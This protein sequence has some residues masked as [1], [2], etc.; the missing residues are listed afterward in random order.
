MT[1]PLSWGRGRH[2]R[3]LPPSPPPLF[4]ERALASPR[5]NKDLTEGAMEDLR[6]EEEKMK[7]VFSSSTY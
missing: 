4:V 2:E 6:I 5:L 7:C 3:R 1:Y